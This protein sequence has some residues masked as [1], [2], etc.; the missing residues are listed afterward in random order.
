MS[1]VDLERLA[2]LRAS[3]LLT[4]DLATVP[5][6]ATASRASAMMRRL[7]VRHLPV[8]GASGLIGVLHAAALEHGEGSV[9][10]HVVRDVGGGHEGPEVDVRAPPLSSTRRFHPRTVFRAGTRSSPFAFTG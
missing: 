8:L 10:D 6:T 3:D 2:A 4:G 5:D 9:L 1:P 7:G